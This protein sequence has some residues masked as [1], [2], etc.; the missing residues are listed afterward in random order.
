MNVKSRMR[1]A[2]AAGATVLGLSLL[3]APASADP[4]PAS[5]YRQLVGV[6][7]DTTQ[8]IGNALG[9]TFADS[10]GPSSRLIASYDA[11]GTTP[12]KTRVLGCVIA[13]PNGSSPGIDALRN[14]ISASTGCIDFARSS[15]G[16]VDLSTTRLTWIPF[17]KD[18]V[19]A[20]VRSDSPLNDAVGFNTGQ[21]RTIYSCAKTTHNGVALTPLLPHPGSG[22]RTFFLDKIG[23]TEAQ[24]GACVNGTVQPNDGLALDTAGDI[25]PY[26]VAQYIAQTSDVA[27]DRHGDTVLTRVDGV[28]P[29]NASGTLNVNFPYNRDVYNVVPTAK[30]NG[31]P[32]PDT[33]LISTFQ[34]TVSRVCTQANLIAA[35]GFGTL[36][37]A[38]GNTNIKAER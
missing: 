11:V 35:Y 8:D 15:R 4:V 9:L 33:D 20:V 36:G 16:P 32:T 24:V 37:N 1:T 7:S 28:T 18:A 31:G 25:A 38:C 26:S 30:L 3:T 10:N 27:T 5:D 19:T 2:A 13:R 23:L 14:A 22:T 21:L 6:G 12:I 34:G 17:A 29:R